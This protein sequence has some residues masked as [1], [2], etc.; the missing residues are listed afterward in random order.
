MK[1][2]GLFFWPLLAGLLLASGLAQAQLTIVGK[3]ANGGES[4]DIFT[5]AKDG[6]K[7]AGLGF[8][9]KVSV[10]P[11]NADWNKIVALWQK[12]KGSQ[13]AAF[14]VVGSYTETNTKDPSTLTL[15]AG[16]GV[17]FTID[18]PA[19]PG[20][21]N[22]PGTYSFTVPPQDFARFDAD[23]AKVTAFLA[24]N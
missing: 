24:S 5:Y 3:Y 7:S 1:R 21:T 18:Q 9:H 2:R 8:R 20:S 13:G 12:A 10:N 19:Y 6:G 23:L 4:L 15:S 11:G 17:R 14:R 22:K 16:T